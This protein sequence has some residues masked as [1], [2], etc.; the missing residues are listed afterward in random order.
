MLKKMLGKK[1]YVVECLNIKRHLKKLTENNVKLFNV[2]KINEKTLSFCAFSKDDKIIKNEFKNAHISMETNKS[3]LLHFWQIIKKNLAIVISFIICFASFPFLNA[4]VWRI[5]VFCF[6]DLLDVKIQQV[7]KNKNVKAGKI[8]S[9]Y[10]IN[11]IR[12]ELLGEISE[13]AMVDVEIKNQALIINV[14]EKIFP[15]SQFS[16]F[17]PLISQFDGIVESVLIESGTAK[18]KKGD[19]VRSG[20]ILAEAYVQRGSE[21]IPCEVKGQIVVRSF[22]ETQEKFNENT[23]I[24]VRTGKKVTK[25]YFTFFKDF[26]RIKLEKCS[27]QNFE[28]QVVCENEQKFPI[29]PIKLTSAVFFELEEKEIFISFKENKEKIEQEFKNKVLNEIG[30]V[31]IFE[32]NVSSVQDGDGVFVL[33]CYVDFLKTY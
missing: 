20:D 6:S 23:K 26:D 13:I 10:N 11:E 7:L 5:D 32:E 25:N 3:G 33:T 31:S 28:V 2:R 9:K 4:F 14:R 15:A 16:S 24:F 22:F 19:F 30:E 29:L 1:E 12:S 27:F 17:S 21:F 18:V 8:K